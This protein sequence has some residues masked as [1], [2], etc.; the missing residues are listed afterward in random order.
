MPATLSPTEPDHQ[1]YLKKK[2]RIG[3]THADK[4]NYTNDQK[5]FHED[6]VPLSVKEAK[7][8]VVESKKTDILGV[9]PATW[10]ASVRPESAEDSDLRRTLLKV[11]AGLMD[12]PPAAANRSQSVPRSSQRLDLS[13]AP[14]DRPWNCST[15]QDVKERSTLFEQFDRTCRTSSGRIAKTIEPKYT[16][17]IQRQKQLMES[18]R[19]E[20]EQ[21]VEVRHKIR[22]E[23]LFL[24][25]SA[26]EAKSTAAVHRILHETRRKEEHAEGKRNQKPDMTLTTISRRYKEFYHPGIWE[27]SN[28]EHRHGWS[29]CMNFKK[30]S[31]GCSYSVQNP[32]SWCLDSY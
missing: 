10:K 14:S 25:P 6:D 17:P 27:F 23:Y 31:Q 2:F 5:V 24:N 8:K 29:C 15:A 20:K 7:R 19:Q 32:D 30:D 11:R 28:I 16:P 21:T 9:R 18:L 22:E 13:T 4:I 3:S 12:A 26:S 1:K